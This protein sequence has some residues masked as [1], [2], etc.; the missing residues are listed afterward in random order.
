MPLTEV[1][2]SKYLQITW[3]QIITIPIAQNAFMH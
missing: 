1:Q 2:I 3:I